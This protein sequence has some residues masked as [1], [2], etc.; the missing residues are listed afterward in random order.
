MKK[1][2]KNLYYVIGLLL[3]LSIILWINVRTPTA[4]CIKEGE[5]YNAET[6]PSA[7]C[8]EGLTPKLDAIVGSIGTCGI[9]ECPCYRCI[10]CGDGEC[11]L[12][13]NNCICPEDC[14]FKEEF[15]TADLINTTDLGKIEDYYQGILSFKDLET[16]EGYKIFLCVKEWPIFL[17]GTCYRF[18]PAEIERNVKNQILPELKEYGCYTGTFEKV[19]CE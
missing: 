9:A 13:E 2:K 17:E 10:N 5:M 14:Q 1:R 15:I 7:K 19:S 6:S 16:N 11:G 18:S 4:E 3:I 8:C 12:G